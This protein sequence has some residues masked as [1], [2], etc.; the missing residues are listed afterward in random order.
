MC[1]CFLRILIWLSIF[2]VI[3]PPALLFSFPLFAF[4]LCLLP[5]LL[6]PLWVSLRGCLRLRLLFCCLLLPLLWGLLLSLLRYP[7]LRLLRV[8][9]SLPLLL[10]IPSLTSFSSSAPV[11]GFLLLQPS[12]SAVDLSR[13]FASGSSIFLSALRSPSLPHSFPPAPALGFPPW[14]PAPSST[15]PLFVASFASGLLLSPLRYPFLRLL[16]VPVSLPLLLRIPSL[17]SVSSSAP[18]PGF[19]LLQPSPSA[20][21]SFLPLL[22]FLLLLFFWVRHLYQGW[23]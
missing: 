18:V 6:L 4:P 14:M 23:V 5:F 17:T 10:R 22:R 2:H 8:P 20:L 21:P 7:F 15:V 9:V 13:D 19:L 11:T 16:R 1:L 3:L 12:P